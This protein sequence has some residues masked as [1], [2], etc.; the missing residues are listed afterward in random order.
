MVEPLFSVAKGATPHVLLE[1]SQ[2]LMQRLDANSICLSNIYMENHK[3]FYKDAKFGK[4]IIARQSNLQKV[5]NVTGDLNEIKLHEIKGN[6]FII[7]IDKLELRKYQQW[8]HI[9]LLQHGIRNE[10]NDKNERK[11]K[12]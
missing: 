7:T 2:R 10:S 4:N 6:Y 8:M 3:I 5:A 9:I 11:Y 12:E 1:L